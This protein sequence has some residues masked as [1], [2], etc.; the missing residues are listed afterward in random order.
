MPTPVFLQ[1]VR[2][3]DI[4]L[5]AIG[6]ARTRKAYALSASLSWLGL[7]DVEQA[8]AF[9]SK[10][11]AIRPGYDS[12]FFLG[13]NLAVRGFVACEAGK[14][15]DSEAA[16]D[17][18][19]KTFAELN[20]EGGLFLVSLGRI[21]LAMR[22]GDSEAAVRRLDALRLESFVASRAPLRGCT[23]ANFICVSG[24]PTARPKKSNGCGAQ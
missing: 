2:S 24:S 19:A 8:D 10:A 13:F 23:L 16:F 21:E 11:E 22:T 3:L 18:A 6:D 20:N 15:D 1:T 12:S 7:G 14:L 4:F 5:E 17:A 9:C